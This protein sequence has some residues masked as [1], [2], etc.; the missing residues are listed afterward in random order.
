MYEYTCNI[1]RSYPLARGEA[2]SMW[3]CHTLLQDHSS[4]VLVRSAGEATCNSTDCVE[5][6]SAFLMEGDRVDRQRQKG[7]IG[8]DKLLD[9]DQRQLYKL[10]VLCILI[11]NKPPCIVHSTTANSGPNL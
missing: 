5:V 8:A 6:S 10:R 7:E 9:T 4:L 11:S 2:G 3:S 1:I